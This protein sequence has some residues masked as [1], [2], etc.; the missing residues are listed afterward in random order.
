MKEGI[1]PEDTIILTGLQKVVS[2]QPVKIIESADIKQNNSKE[3]SSWWSRIKNLFKNNK[4]E[5]VA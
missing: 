2:G 1:L 4:E 3:E 5:K